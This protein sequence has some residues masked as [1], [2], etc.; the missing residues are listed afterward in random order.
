MEWWGDVNGCVAWIQEN[1]NQ[2]GKFGASGWFLLE[3]W[4]VIVSEEGSGREG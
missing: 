2:L 4:W 1:W 3:Y